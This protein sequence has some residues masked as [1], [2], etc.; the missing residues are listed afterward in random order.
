[1]RNAPLIV[2]FATDLA[3]SG[4]QRR[5]KKSVGDLSLVEAAGAGARV[6]EQ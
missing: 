4:M 5:M 6:V 2:G 1:M 3:D